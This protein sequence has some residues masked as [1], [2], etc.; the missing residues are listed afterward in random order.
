MVNVVC[1]FVFA[2]DRTIRIWIG[3]GHIGVRVCVTRETFDSKD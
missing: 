1:N 3:T 2:L